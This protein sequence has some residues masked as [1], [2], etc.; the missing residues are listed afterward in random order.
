MGG[1]E[2]G[3]CA[4]T[5]GAGTGSPRMLGPSSVPKVPPE[6]AISLEAAPVAAEQQPLR[7]PLRRLD[8]AHPAPS[9]SW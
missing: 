8:A 3:F 7:P 5:R 1:A 4:E 6:L 9:P 2:R